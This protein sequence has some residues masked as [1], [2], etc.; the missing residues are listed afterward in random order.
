MKEL[1]RVGQRERV[2]LSMLKSK[3]EEREGGTYI[4]TRNNA[5]TYIERQILRHKNRRE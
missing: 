4:H 2:R 1:R 3:G 5:K